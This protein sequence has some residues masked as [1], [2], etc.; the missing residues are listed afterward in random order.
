MIPDC[1]LSLVRSQILQFKTRLADL[2]LPL[3]FIIDTA[4]TTAHPNKDNHDLRIRYTEE[5]IM[6]IW[7]MRQLSDPQSAL[8]WGT[9]PTEIPHS[10][11]ERAQ[12]AIREWN[13]E[14]LVEW[15]EDAI[16]S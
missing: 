12:S 8:V 2:E 15:P 13:P 10:L 9:T 11:I 1:T 7:R 16:I 6:T 5:I 14:G 3:W 4:N